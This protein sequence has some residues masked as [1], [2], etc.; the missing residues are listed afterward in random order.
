MCSNDPGGAAE[1]RD[2]AGEER[3]HAG[4]ERDRAGGQ[5]DRVAHLARCAT[6]DSDQWRCGAAGT[7]LGHDSLPAS[8]GREWGDLIMQRAKSGA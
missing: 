7:Q 1:E 3:D 4:Q 5:R 8:I 2:L 6:R